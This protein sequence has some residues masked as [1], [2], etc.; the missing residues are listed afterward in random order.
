MPILYEDPN[1][2]GLYLTGSLMELDPGLYAFNSNTSIVEWRDL[3]FAGQSDGADYVLRDISGWEEL[4][5]YTTQKVAVGGGH[6]SMVAPIQIDERVVTV[7]GWCFNRLARD[8]LM[9][10]FQRSMAPGLD[11]MQTEPL[12]VF[13][14]GR[15]LQ[16]DARAVAFSALPEAGWALGRFAWVAQ[17]LC[18]DPLRYGA[19][20]TVT[21]FL[22]QPG[23]GLALPMS[24]PAAFPDSSP[25]GQFDAV[26]PGTALAPA[27]YEL[28]GPIINPGVLLNSGTPYQQLIQYGLTLAQGDLLVI[29]TSGGG[30]GLLNGEYRPPLGGGSLTKDLMLRP[31]TNTVQALGTPQAG[32]PLP[33]ISCTFRPAY[34]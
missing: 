28:S 17:W 3:I 6:G 1:N 11:G 8:F 19:Y 20:K 29:N 24:L 26:N 16:A 34:W 13:H 10:E 32:D 5:S 21:S 33:S 30:S 14:A 22:P 7:T 25:G 2:P 12:S 9:S 27:A 4:P 31:G 15:T 18:S 23:A